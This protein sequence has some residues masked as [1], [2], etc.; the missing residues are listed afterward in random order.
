MPDGQRLTL[1]VRGAGYVQVTWNG[2]VVAH[3][4][5]VPGTWTAMTFDVPDI[6]L[7]T[8]ELAV[9]PVGIAVSD[10]ELSLLR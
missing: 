8:N 1:W 10:L 7:H 2:D 5:I 4:L 6:A 9:L 3:G